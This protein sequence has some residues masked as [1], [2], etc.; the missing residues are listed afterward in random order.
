MHSLSIVS[1]CRNPKGKIYNHCAQHDFFSDS[2]FKSVELSLTLDLDLSLTL[3]KSV[4]LSL[5]LDL[6]LS[7]TLDVFD[8]QLRGLHCH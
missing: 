4:D 3:F 7:L 1:T 8:W 2:I 5:T 6:D